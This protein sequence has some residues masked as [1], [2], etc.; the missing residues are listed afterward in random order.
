MVIKGARAHNL[1]NIN[2]SI[3][4]NTFTVITGV[5]GSGKSSI[6]F[7]T[8]YAEGQRRYVESL[9]TYA[10]QFLG[11][12]D[13]A[14]VDSIEGLS[15][16]IAIEQRTT[17]RNPRSTVG[18]VTEIHDHMRLLWA[19]VGI[20]H[21]PDC[22][23]EVMAMPIERITDSILT[24][25]QNNKVI[26]LAPIASGKKGTFKLEL[27]TLLRQGFVRIKIDGKIVTIDEKTEL[28]KNIRHDIDV[29]VDR[30][31]SIEDNR[32]R[33][34]EAVEIATK[35]ANGIVAVELE[36]SETSRQVYSE[37]NACPD[38]GIGFEP[39][40][41]K[42]F[43][44]NSP[45]GACSECSGLGVRF[46]I[47][48]EK[49]IRDPA[50]SI[51]DGAI[52]AWGENAEE[53]WYGKAL[54]VV[55]KTEKVDLNKPWKNLPK[56]FQ[57]IVLYG[58][59]E[60]R[61]KVPWISQRIKA[62]INTKFEGVIPNL[63]RRYK[64]T[65]ST[66]IRE[67]I[68]GFMS[69]KICQACRGERLKPESRAVTVDGV[70]LPEL[71]SKT[72]GEI[73]SWL[74]SLKLDSTKM[75]IADR[76]IDELKNRL[77]FLKEVGLDYLTLDR[78]AATL[79]G[80]EAQRIRLATQLGSRLRGVLYV[81][82][83]PSIGLHPA[84]TESLLNT[85]K[86]LRD[87]GNTV[88]VVE[89]DRDTIEAAD[90]VI[91]M[92]PGAGK[93]GGMIIA[94]GTPSEITAD[95]NSLT[96]AYLSGR[97]RIEHDRLPR[98]S[99]A[100]VRISGVKTNNL[101]NISVSFPLGHLICI[102]GVS[103]SGKSS[104]VMDT[105][106]PVI[107]RKLGLS[108]DK[109]GPFEK[110]EGI[111]NIDKI[112]CIDQSPIGRSSRSNPATYTGV[113]TVIRELFSMTKEAR[114]RGYLPGRFSFNVKGG[115]C[116]E[117]AGDGVKTVEMH[118]LPDVYVLCEACKGKR[119]N[120]ETLEVKY[121]GLSISDV[122]N[123]SIEDA[124]EFFSNIP[125]AKKWLNML[126]E[127]GLGYL[128]LG[129]SSTTLSGGEAQRLKLASELGKTSSGR[130]L[131]VMDE[132]T[133]GLH[134]DDVRI[135][136]RVLDRFV[137]RGDTVIVVEHHPDIMAH[138]DTII[139]LGPGSGDKGGMVVAIGSPHDIALNKESLTGQ[140]MMKYFNGSYRL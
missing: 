139:D 64:E 22:G 135:L 74:D 52:A 2:V 88:V 117:C 45:H 110:I 14:D 78:N 120:R 131:Y 76:L 13:K 87:L 65:K 73:D 49:V 48:S 3:P 27:D 134:F 114:E 137:D 18:T 25:T 95:S 93:H 75:R 90:Y 71:L 101:K 58:S 59:G 133:T 104:L 31:L 79:S 28:E 40:D 51:I 97:R 56:H 85:L 20:P 8:L 107:R 140:V 111:E 122:L 82:D 112:I 130:S 129:Q 4:H 41:P 42:H 37:K 34:H 89:H 12:M 109:P 24:L 35:L 54:K 68:E 7:D 113:F 116:E 136:I 26:I 106:V 92:G 99:R 91:D 81:L 70:R 1:R 21:C 38:C 138:S 29:V 63:V 10:R 50:L 80:G 128:Q 94:E 9:S 123:M 57:E 36:S 118:F 43:S 83:E 32:S 16:A 17:Q 19:R 125:Q 66:Y 108:S 46:E 127:V 23:R 119:Y 96:G 102:T 77:N 61:Y 124:A 105:L 103:G 53:K 84:D 62:E 44:F 115:R 100:S 33:I 47:D 126:C 39:L 30:I 72:V 121:K 60:R 86:D 55:S 98:D 69:M 5:S 6:A 15:P 11:Q 132:P 67:W